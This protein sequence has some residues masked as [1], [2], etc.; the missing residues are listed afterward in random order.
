MSKSPRW[1]Q[2]LFAAG[3]ASA[4]TASAADR[5][6]DVDTAGCQNNVAINGAIGQSFKL[7]AQAS[8]DSIDIW[9]RPNLYYYTTYRVDLYA[10][11]G[12]GTLLGSSAQFTLGCQ[13]T[14][15]S[16]GT[17]AVADWRG[18][19]FAGQNVTLQPNTAY[20]FKLVRLSQYSGA[21]G[22]RVASKS[23]QRRSI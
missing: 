4:G 12:G 17:A 7:G 8:L 2:L 23:S 3:L 19:S 9:I 10:G 18:F 11:E 21:F 1:M 16:C 22:Y 20:T 13:Q 6:I 5:L 15:Y 14:G